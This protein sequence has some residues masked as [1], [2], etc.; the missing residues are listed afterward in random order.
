MNEPKKVLHWRNTETNVTG[1]G[2][3]LSEANAEKWLKL[4]KEWPDSN[5]EYWLETVE[6]EESNGTKQ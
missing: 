5:F 4:A 6:E 2:Q 1:H 3:P